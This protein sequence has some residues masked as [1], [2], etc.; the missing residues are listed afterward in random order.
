MISAKNCKS[1]VPGPT[2][3]ERGFSLI[4]L[5]IVVAIIG[6]LAGIAIP[7]Y[8]SHVV[9]AR[10]AAAESFIL[11]IANTENQVLLDLRQYVS[12]ANNTNFPNTPTAAS[13]G[14]NT[15]VPGDVSSYYDVKVVATNSTTAPPTF[16]V[17]AVP[18]GG[19]ATS[20]TACATVTID[21]AGT[22]GITGTG[23]VSGCW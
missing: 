16:V 19:Q 10:R 12:V 1:A 14:L 4:E 23:S 18:K 3:R 11:G 20:D 22:K 15:T 5:M 6:I 8:T 13:P 17:S 21:Q 7:S 9:K 2:A